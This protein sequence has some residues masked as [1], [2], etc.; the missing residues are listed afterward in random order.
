MDATIGAN[1]GGYSR[2]VLGFGPI[3]YWP[4]DEASG[5]VAR[6]LVN[7]LQNGTYTGV[8]LADDSSGPFGT[9]APFFDGANDYVNVFTAAL[10]AAFDG[11]EGSAGIWVRVANAGVWTDG[12]SR[13]SIYIGADGN[14]WVEQRKDAVNNTTRKRYRANGTVSAAVAA[15]SYATWAYWVI[16][17]S[18]SAGATGEYKSYLNGVQEGVTQVN[19]DNWA[20]GLAFC[21]IGEA[22]GVPA[23]VWH[24]WLAH[25]ALWDRA[26]SASEILDLANP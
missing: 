16:T 1:L 21:Y 7:P 19:I 26:L 17:W 25:G 13:Y 15:A 10:S 9:P 22:N 8:T 18:R 4:L 3:A 2:K 20:G 24:G 11:Q 6:C 23:S 12:A 14:N 5:G